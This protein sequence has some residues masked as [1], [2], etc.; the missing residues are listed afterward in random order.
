MT[1]LSYFETIWG[2]CDH[3]S[4]L[5]AY[6]AN[7]VSSVLFPDELLRSEW[8]AR[9]SALD[10]YIHELVAQLM[11]ACFE[12][13]FCPSS[14]YQRF[15][16]SN[17]VLSRIRKASSQAEASAAYDFEVRNQLSFRTFQS[18]E[19]IADGIRLV[20]D[21]E[22]WNE[23]AL[24]AGASQSTKIELAK[25]L[26]RDL[27]LIVQRRNKIAHEGDLQLAY[28]REPWLINQVD[29]VFVKEQIKSLVYSINYLVWDQNFGT[30]S[31]SH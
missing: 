15:Q 5:H 13:S 12:G 17:E 25:N 3:I 18:P 26:K 9:V 19:N 14:A 7:S 11:V 4:A 30:V 16:L 2:R 6:L 8:V 1:P 20:S 23:I 21:I 24:R 27:S 22:L 28:P 31:G 10:F 29:L